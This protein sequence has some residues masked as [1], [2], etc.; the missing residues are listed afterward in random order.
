MAKVNG[1]IWA[2]IIGLIIIFLQFLMP[3]LV[4]GAVA[5]LLSRDNS[6]FPGLEPVLK[7]FLFLRV[8]GGYV[9]FLVASWARLLASD[10]V[11]LNRFR[12]DPTLVARP[13][14]I[15]PSIATIAAKI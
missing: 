1:W 10:A 6:Q 8:I 13:P 4:P 11:N 9:L 12:N 3:D 7:A 2:S 15:P 14:I 5:K